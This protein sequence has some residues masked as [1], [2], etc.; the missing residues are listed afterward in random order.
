MKTIVIHLDEHDDLISVRDRM[1][2]SKSQR[3]LLVWPEEDQPM[4]ARKYDLVSLQRHANS[5]GAQLGLFTRDADVRANAR[6]LGISV[7]RN[8]KQAQRQRWGRIRRRR[9]FHRRA[10]NVERADGLRVALGERKTSSYSLGWSRLMI[11]SIGVLA[12]LGM[13]VF[14]LPGATIALEPVQIDQRVSMKLIAD[15]LI[16]APGI[17]GVIPARKVSTVVEVQGEIPASGKTRLPDQKAR[18]TVEIINLTDQ[19]LIIPAGAILSVPGTP[20]LRFATT[21]EVGLQAVGGAAVSVPVQA[22]GGG[23][24]GNLPAGTVFSLEGSLGPNVAVSNPAGFT[25]GS[26]LSV[27]AP[28]KT[29]YEKLRQQLLATLLDRAGADLATAMG[30]EEQMLAG[31]LKLEQVL[32]E[33]LLPEVGS[34]GDRLRLSLRA[35]YSGYSI[36]RVDLNQLAEVT[37]DAYLPAGRRAV[38]ASLI[39]ETTGQ[40]RMLADGRIEWQVTASRKTIPD[41]PRQDLQKAVL[42]KRPEDAAKVLAT[43]MQLE[44]PPRIT[45]NPSWWFWMPSLGFRIQIEGL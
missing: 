33:S 32:E 14:L 24:A 30:S 16:A 43:L 37:L 41:L 34:P 39:T 13:G 2:W 15:P 38:P 17:N 31:T 40:P 26:D 10:Q 25:G 7:F 42:G 28:S 27:P 4:L 21:R 36:S 44:Q 35:E 20:Q 23:T 18:G 19:P 8:E 6:E 29:D 22:I 3:I 45:L 11:F 12:V 5:L 1:V 9:R